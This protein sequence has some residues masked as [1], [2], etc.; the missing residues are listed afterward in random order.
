MS[1]QTLV[2]TIM[3]FVSIHWVVEN[4]V[5]NFFLWAL[6]HI[7]IQIFQDNI[8]SL[9]NSFKS[10]NFYQKLFEKWSKLLSEKCD[11][12]ATFVTKQGIWELP[13]L[14]ATVLNLSTNRDSPQIYC[15]LMLPQCCVFRITIWIISQNIFSKY[16]NIKNVT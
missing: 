8:K 10:Y 1:L 7:L 15:I 4:C 3:N 13:C 14:V 6:F 2:F 11:V 12:A 16:C 9:S 5:C